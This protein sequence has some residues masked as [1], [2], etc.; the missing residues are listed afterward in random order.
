MSS[1]ARDTHGVSE[2]VRVDRPFG[3]LRKLFT[4]ALMAVLTV[5]DLFAAQAILPSLSRHYLVSPGQ[6]AAAVNASTLGMAVASLLVALFN[7]KL[8]RRNGILFSLLLLSIPTALLAYAPGIT[9]FAALRI[10]QGL[11]MASAFSLTFA[12]L[13]EN[14]SP[15][16]APHAFAA[17]ITGNVVSNLVGRFVAA[18]VAEHAGLAQTFLCLAALNLLGALFAFFFI[19]R[20]PARSKAGLDDRVPLAQRLARHF[21]NPNL[22]VAFAIGFLILFVFIG[23]FSFINFVLMAPPLSVSM[24]QIGLIYFVFLPSIVTTALAEYAHQRFGTK[25]TLWASFLVAGAGLPLLLSPALGAVLAGMTLVAAGTFFA[26]AA[27]SGFANRAAKFDSG[28][29]SGLY[30][31]SYFLGG[32]AGSLVLGQILESFGWIGCVGAIGAALFAACSCVTMLDE[33]VATQR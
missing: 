23:T 25:R 32:I 8:A 19:D 18:A 33:R 13:G 7:A 4:I 31:A 15:A 14:L 22:R 5:I 20:A 24:M 29:A 12:Y 21:E 27:V 6:M 2:T 30:L 3:R 9:T 17:Y 16:E 10:S 1:T 11:L 26:Q 28:A